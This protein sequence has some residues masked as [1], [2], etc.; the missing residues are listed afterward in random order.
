MSTAR[1]LN[2]LCLSQ[3]KI[4]VCVR[5]A[6]NKFVILVVKMVH[7]Q[8]LHLASG[9]LLAECRHLLCPIFTIR[10]YNIIDNNSRFLP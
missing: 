3:F 1:T 7:G 6:D 2:L 5:D 9:I 8:Y 10:I 4:N